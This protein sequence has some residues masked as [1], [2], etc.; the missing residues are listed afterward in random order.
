MLNFTSSTDMDFSNFGRE[1]WLE[2][3]NFSSHEQA[4]Q[5]VVKRLFEEFVTDDGKAQLALVRIFRLTDIDDLPSTVRAIVESGEQRVMALTGTWGTEKAWQDRRLSK[6]HQAIPLS[7]IAVPEKIP[8]FQEVLTQL[9]IDLEHFYRTKEIITSSAQPYQGTFYIPDAQSP[10]IPA[11]DGFVQPYGIKSLV[12]FGG[13]IGGRQVMYLLYAFSRV[14]VSAEAAQAFYRL[15][16][17][18]GTT[19]AIDGKVFAD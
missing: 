13:F 12:G 14:P 2:R 11:Q 8:M 15:Q 9:G 18:V 10:A 17:F 3:G 1:L 16:E 5:F 19:I 7:A 4:S 6:G